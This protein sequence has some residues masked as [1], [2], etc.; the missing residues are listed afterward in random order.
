MEHIQSV[1]FDT[2]RFAKILN[3]NFV[4]MYIRFTTFYLYLLEGPK[5][6]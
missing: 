2:V 5:V 3:I 1:L 6:E 4:Y